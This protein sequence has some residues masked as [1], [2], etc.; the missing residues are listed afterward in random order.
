MLIIPNI[1]YVAVI[2]AAVVAVIIGFIYYSPPLF[3]KIMMRESHMGPKEMQKRMGMLFVGAIISAF[4]AS[5]VLEFIVKGLGVT[6]ITEGVIVGLLVWIGFY[7]SME[8]VSMASG[9]NSTRLFFV[10]ILHHLIVLLVMVAILVTL[11]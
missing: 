7:V 4:F 2:A 9:R 10:N 1:N 11:M 5:F 3:G 8:L 6:T